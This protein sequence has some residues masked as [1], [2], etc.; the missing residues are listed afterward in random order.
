MKKAISL[1]LA[2]ILC[3]SLTACGK[4]EAVKNVEAMIDALTEATENLGEE[5][6]AVKD[7]YDDLSYEEQ[8]KV[9]NYDDFNAIRDS[10]YEQVL[11]GQ[12]YPLSLNLYEPEHIFAPRYHI[13]LNADMSFTNFA[14]DSG[15]EV[16]QWEV[17]EG[18][19]ILHGINGLS[20]ECSGSFSLE[21]DFVS[22]KIDRTDGFEYFCEDSGIRYYRETEYRKAV[23]DVVMAVDCSQ[24]DLS[25]Y[26]GFSSM[27]V[28]EFDEWGAHTGTVYNRVVLQN[29][30]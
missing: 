27:E 6:I 8:K 28:L 29:L 24:V 17:K 22:L 14:Y 19:L 30:L 9:K 5:I 23:T 1:L 15:N 26:I 13:T 7:A 11:V 21:N 16:G 2:L 10:Y 20:T 3:L 4:S 12:W 25:E 18:N